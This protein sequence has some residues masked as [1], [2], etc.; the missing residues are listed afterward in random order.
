M[1]A[2]LHPVARFPE[3]WKEVLQS[4]GEKPYRAGQVFRWIHQRGVMDPEQMTDLGKSLRARLS[5]AG[6]A[7]PF[8]VAEVLRSK[9]GTRKLLL[10][11]DGGGRVECVLI[12]MTRDAAPGDSGVEDADAAAA[13]FDP[14]DQAAPR[15]RVTLCISTQYGCAMG[16]VFCASGQAGLQR[17]LRADEIVAQVLVAKRYLEPDEDLRNLVFMGMGEP[18][19]HYEQTQR[20]IQLI[21]HP[22]GLGMSPRRITVSSVGL[23]PGIR[24]LGEDFGGKVGLAIS[25]HAPDN[26][27]R[28]RIL[29]M[30]QRYPVEELVRALHDYPLPVRRRITIEYTLIDGV[31]DSSAHC[32]RLIDLLAGLRVKVNLIP[33]NPISASE[34]KAP[35]SARV[36]AFRERLADAGVSC[37]VRV[38]RGDDVDAACGQLA[39]HG[40]P[41]KLRKKFEGT[42]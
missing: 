1:S 36:S 33:M 16:C 17:G 6:L 24:K 37:F 23:V 30:N 18:L 8:R 39:L 35:S 2:E 26:E 5:D 41:I 20:A 12:P 4:L 13:S 14:D 29:P 19:H 3:E 25:L 7:D 11:L 9:D 22:D 21:T 10:E 42:E 40:E 15:E 32:D 38:R 34:L 31:N 28:S 27:T